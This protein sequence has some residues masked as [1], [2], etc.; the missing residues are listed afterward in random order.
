MTTG[1]WAALVAAAF[2]AI[3]DWIAVHRR[4]KS[5][6]Y[7]CKP[8]TLVAVIVAALALDPVDD[9]QRWWFVAAFAF[10]LAG[11][12]FLMLPE[13]R[14]AGPVDTFVA[15]LASFLAGHVAF[16]AGF[17][18]RG[19]DLFGRVWVAVGV[20]MLWLTLGRRIVRGAR[21]HDRRLTGPVAAY[22]GVLSAMTAF[23][24]AVG[25]GWAIAGGLL[26][27]C[28]DALLG[29]NRFVHEQRHGRLAV[30]VTYHLAQASL[31]LSLAA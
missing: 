5:T 31:L 10:S 22:V 11:D 16:V 30:I 15:G 23:A 20:V 29:W 25:G 1:A 27:V 24:V 28:S 21:E 6:E 3:G 14:L 13:R 8:L 17:A 4:S 12:V 7:L 9:A 19:A 18:V 26:F 2:A